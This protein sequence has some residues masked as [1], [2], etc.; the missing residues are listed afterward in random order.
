MEGNRKETH[1]R[2]GKIVFMTVIGSERSSKAQIT[3]IRKPVAKPVL[4]EMFIFYTVDA[5]SEIQRSQEFTFP[6]KSQSTGTLGF[7]CAPR[8]TKSRSFSLHSLYISMA[9]RRISRLFVIILFA[10]QTTVFL[11]AAT[12]FVVMGALGLHGGWS[13]DAPL[14]LWLLLSGTFRSLFFPLIIIIIIILLLLHYY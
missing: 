11:L 9:V 7:L 14:S 13:C 5:K 6:Y 12:P 3:E 4:T 2:N 10:A 8:P 1:L